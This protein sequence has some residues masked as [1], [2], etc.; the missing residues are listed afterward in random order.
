MYVCVCVYVWNVEWGGSVVVVVVV[1]KGKR[2]ALVSFSFFYFLCF[3][4]R[5][6]LLGLVKE[7]LLASIDCNN[8]HTS[9]TLISIASPS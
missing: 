2:R 1:W 5:C 6:S 3:F 9:S 4:V 8:H 7:Y